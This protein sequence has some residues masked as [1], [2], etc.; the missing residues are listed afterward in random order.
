M[1]LLAWQTVRARKA[2][3]AGA[4]TALAFA[5]VLTAACGV[6]LES[7]LRTDQPT[8]RY[9]AAPVVVGDSTRIPDAGPLVAKLAELPG[10]TAAVPEVSFPA[11]VITP[12]GKVLSGPQGG[13]SLGHS[14]TSAVLAPFR[15]TSGR[16]PAGPD[17][18][19]LDAA[20]AA[21]A[22]VPAGG[23]VRLA[24]T[25][26]PRSYTVAGLASPPRELSRQSALFFSPEQAARLAGTTTG[27]NAIGITAAEGTDPRALAQQAGQ[28][29]AEARPQNDDDSSGPRARTGDERGEL[30]F[31][32]APGPGDGLSSLAGTMGVL[33]LF[34]SV[35]VVAGAL[36]LS[37]QQRMREM[38]LLR[39]VGATTGQVRRMIALETLVLTLAAAVVGVPLG[40]GLAALLRGE[41][42]DRGVVSSDVPLHVGPTAPLIVLGGVLVTAQLAVWAA[43]RRASRVEPTQALRDSSAPP[44]GIGRL[45]TGLGLA[46]L[47]V[48]GAVLAGSTDDRGGAGTAEGMVLVLLL[49]VALIGP[50]IG[51]V[52]SATIG[53]PVGRLFPVAGF[54]ASAALR[55]QPRRFAAAV[56]PLVLAVAFTGT[57]LFVPV[58]KAQANV[59]EDGRRLLADHVVQAGGIGLPVEFTDAVRKL[60]GVGAAGSLVSGFVMV[61][62]GSADTAG[63]HGVDA[64]IVDPQGLEQLV[65]PGV[66]AGSLDRLRG[67]TIALGQQT[68][69]RLK[70]GVGATVRIRWEDGSDSTASVVAV[71]DRDA[72]F[73]GALLPAGF[74]AA[75]TPDPL[76]P[77]VLVR[78]APGA[79]PRQVGRELQGLTSAY[80]MARISDRADYDAARRHQQEAASAVG[81]LLLGMISLFTA[82]AVVNTLVM[83]TTERLR[84]FALL[85]LVGTTPAQVLRMMA[86]EGGITVAVAL[87]LGA[88]VTAAVLVPVSLAL[89]GTAWPSLPGSW[90]AAVLGGAALLGVGT[91]LLTT[92]LA[93]RREPVEAM[94]TRE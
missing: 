74:A 67:E 5:L 26:A 68:A 40:I 22:G 17:E 81:R 12:D 61:S 94:G 1:L 59:A 55:A 23:T 43:A 20:T 62:G 83:A 6:L 15:L 72:R 42:V 7:A 24:T 69:S 78:T 87:A 29:V 8:E 65:D 4:F 52:A 46:T 30:E 33:S 86:W 88:A 36:A 9:A 2:G 44:P 58:V 92:R 53:G 16:A 41:L 85:R 35:F 56:T 38:A 89:T 70:A 75:H 93:L 47:A 21:R 80:P 13:P 63:S 76:A 60:P 91:V 27:A 3:F 50:L 31:Y 39:A 84:E 14:W 90:E 77:T 73:A 10:V 48:C 71:Y 82:I 79:D 51:R 18:V 32:A 28:A 45:R 19:V 25:S 64:R 37:V 57:V 54:L 34:V 49:G 11:A 66:T